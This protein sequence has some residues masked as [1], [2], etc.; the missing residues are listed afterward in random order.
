[1]GRKKITPQQT[2]DIFRLV[3]T[4]FVPE[5][6]L[7]N[8][9]IYGAEKRHSNWVIE[10]REKSDRIPKV[11]TN[12]N[13]VLDGFCD[14]IEM[15][16]HGFSAGPVYLKLYRRRFKKST[17]DKHYSND[18]DL[19]LKGMKLVPELGIFLKEGDRRLPH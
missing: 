14:P 16:S 15:L 13:V 7:E 19:T 11:L 5:N 8:F 1:M 10:L 4:M 9:D 18:Y 17:E 12:E 2:E 6:I 3:S